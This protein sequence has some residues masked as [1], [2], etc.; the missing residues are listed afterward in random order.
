[1]VTV[2]GRVWV[3]LG[4]AMRKMTKWKVGNSVLVFRM[5]LEMLDVSKSG[6]R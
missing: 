5:C 2:D 4:V 1:M 6:G 3:M